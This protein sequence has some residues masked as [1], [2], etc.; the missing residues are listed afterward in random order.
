MFN[1]LRRLNPFR[2]SLQKTRES[3]FSRV[4]HLFTQT[5]IDDA[6]WDELET[7]LIRADVGSAIT[8][9][10]IQHLQTLVERTGMTQ[11]HDLEAALRD[12]LLGLLGGDQDTALAR[13]Q[14]RTV[15]MVIG[16]NGV[17]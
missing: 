17:G 8:A 16:V 13:V 5:V 14:P 2:E 10:V 6:L 9:N 15:I 3:V 7:L 12:E 1:R 11:A 4:T